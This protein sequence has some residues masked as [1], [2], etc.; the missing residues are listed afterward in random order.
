[1]PFR[2]REELQD[3]IHISV[4]Q[5][6]ATPEKFDGKLVAVTGFLHIGHKADLLYLSQEDYNHALAENAIWFNLS[7]EMGRDRERVNK[8]YVG[9]VGIFRASPSGGYPCPNG[10]L[11]DVKRYQLWS[12]LGSPTGLRLDE[13]KKPQ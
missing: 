13:S 7:E 8:N 2:S 11:D 9:L 6:I 12:A 1:M 10:G 3:P 5:L 4:I